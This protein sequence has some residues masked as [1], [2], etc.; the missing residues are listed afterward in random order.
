LGYYYNGFG[1]SNSQYNNLTRTLHI[2]KDGYAAKDSL[3]KSLHLLFFSQVLE[4]YDLFA[5]NQHYLFFNIVGL[6]NMEIFTWGLSAF[7]TLEHFSIMPVVFVNFN[8][9]ANM[10]LYLQLAGNFGKPDTVFAESPLEA[11]LN[12]GIQWSF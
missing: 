9:N 7:I 6:Q 4:Q 2:A 3:W 8:V 1:F 12:G 11:S 5:L 10:K